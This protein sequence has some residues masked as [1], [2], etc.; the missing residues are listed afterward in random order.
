MKIISGKI[1]WEKIS[2]ASRQDSSSKA[3]LIGAYRGNARIGGSIAARW[4]RFFIMYKAAF[5]NAFEKHTPSSY[6]I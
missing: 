1:E 4:C 6:I 2:A 3:T 5:V